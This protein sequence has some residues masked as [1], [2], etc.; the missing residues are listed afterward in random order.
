M[1]KVIKPEE[2]IVAPTEITGQLNG[3]ASDEK[4][5]SAPPEP[6][7]VVLLKNIRHSTGVRR[8]GEKIA[9]KEEES[10]QLIAAKLA[11]LPE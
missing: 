9:V 4:Q 5:D 7:V 6:V 3:Q 2:Q 10:E 1:A 8:K 11:R